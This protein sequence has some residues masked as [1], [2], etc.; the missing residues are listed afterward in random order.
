M[1]LLDDILG[2]PLMRE[3][4]GRITTDTYN[5]PDEQAKRLWQ[6]MPTQPLGDVTTCPGCRAKPVKLELSADG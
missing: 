3:R 5:D 6:S 4:R 1:G 2:K